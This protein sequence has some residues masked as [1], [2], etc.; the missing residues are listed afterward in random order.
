MILPLIF[1]TTFAIVYNIS[2]I[3]PRKIR[4]IYFRFVI[5]GGLSAM[6][7]SL[8]SHYVFNIYHDWMEVEN[9]LNYHIG[10]FILYT[11]MFFYIGQWTR[12]QVLYGP[13]PTAVKSQ[14][15]SPSLSVAPPSAMGRIHSPSVKGNAAMFDKIALKNKNK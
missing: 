11:V 7:V 10:I 8:I 15:S 12:S 13:T 5:C 4:D 2:G 6:I 3:I 9:P 1:A 14:P